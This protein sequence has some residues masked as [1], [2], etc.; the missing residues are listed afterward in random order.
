MKNH[1]R[2]IATLTI[3]LSA[4]VI[5]ACGESGEQGSTSPRTMA[6]TPETTVATQSAP[7]SENTQINTSAQV[8]AYAGEVLDLRS[9][10]ITLPIG[11][12]P[13]KATEVKQPALAT[14]SIDPY[15]QL[16][17]T[18]TAV[19]MRAIAGGART[20]TGTAYSRSELREMT[21]DGSASAAWD[22]AA[23]NRGMYI[24][25]VLTKT[26]TH[27]ADAAIAQVHDAANDN[28]MVLYV[29]PAYPK[30]NGVS[31]TGII[32]VQFNN[33]VNRFDADTNYTLGDK[34][35]IDVSSEAGAMVVTYKNL[36][37]G[38][39]YT[40]PAVQMVGIQGA[41]YFKAG[42]YIQAC[43]KTD[44]YG[45]TN[46]ACVNKGWVDSKYET[47]PYAY[48]ELSMTKLQLR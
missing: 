29:G 25:Q 35:S 37:K 47:D 27:K 4:L 48:S 31:D 20:T 12:D 45:Q 22:C 24:E 7:V 26:T 34:M 30:A 3:A 28:V 5:A 38:T 1:K 44:I 43:S 46:A 18:K 6:Q 2:G 19:L 32:R 23:D 36:T 13:N 14:Y 17:P 15:F 10:K 8:A 11:N 33:G 16:D 9:W 21:S 39:S 42:M 40:T 41:C